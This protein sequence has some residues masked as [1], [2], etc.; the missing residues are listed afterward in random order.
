MFW[1]TTDNNITNIIKITT[2]SFMHETRT[3]KI[4]SGNK[5]KLFQNILTNK[6]AKKGKSFTY[7]L[8][9]DFML[10]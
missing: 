6:L 1:L 4:Q 8:F 3:K 7:P 2:I 5:N 10:T 9:Q